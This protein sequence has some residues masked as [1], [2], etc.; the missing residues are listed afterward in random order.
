MR[1]AC[2]CI[3]YLEIKLL[4]LNDILLDLGVSLPTNHSLELRKLDDDDPC[5]L[6]G[7]HLICRASLLSRVSYIISQNQNPAPPP[8]HVAH[9]HL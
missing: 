3:E 6:I 8:P 1:Q 2:V 9:Q 5:N 7:A 4:L